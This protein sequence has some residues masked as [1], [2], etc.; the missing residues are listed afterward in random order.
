MLIGVIGVSSPLRPSDSRE[1]GIDASVGFPDAARQL[2]QPQRRRPVRNA[3]T[4]KNN[5]GRHS[6]TCIHDSRRDESSAGAPIRFP[7]ANLLPLVHPS[8][9]R[10][11]CTD[12]SVGFPDVDKTSECASMCAKTVHIFVYRQPLGLR[13]SHR[14]GKA[15]AALFAIRHGCHG[16]S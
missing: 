13:L 4:G 8:D 14:T 3:S 16:C 6:Y 10:R 11:S 12:A 1:P 15:D 7:R 9:S 5:Q 2:A